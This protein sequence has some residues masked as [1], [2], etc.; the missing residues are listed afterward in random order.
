MYIP[1]IG[2][3]DKSAVQQET[4]TTECNRDAIKQR[5]SPR[6]IGTGR[7]AEVSHASS[8]TNI[9]EQPKLSYYS[10]AFDPEVTLPSAS[11]D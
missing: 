6:R 1:V 3:D 11:L 7:G 10:A 8:Q 2:L 4:T 9:Y 5:D